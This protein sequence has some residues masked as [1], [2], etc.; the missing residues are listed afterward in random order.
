MKQ[1]ANAR[2]LNL[3]QKR[4]SVEGLAKYGNTHLKIVTK[5][6]ANRG[7]S[8]DQGSELGIDVYEFT[9]QVNVLSGAAI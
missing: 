8:S 4:K 5:D 9:A 6:Y 1:L 2:K 7:G 3:K